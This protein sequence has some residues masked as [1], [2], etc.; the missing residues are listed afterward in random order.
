VPLHV[1]LDRTGVNSRAMEPVYKADRE[2]R[3]G[4]VSSL[5]TLHTQLRLMLAAV[6]LESRRVDR[7]APGC[8]E[9]RSL[10]AVTSELYRAIVLG[11]NEIPVYEMIRQFLHTASEQVMPHHI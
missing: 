3:L 1:G 6:L 7:G 9:H 2:R 11:N 5:P 4:S 8:S 10:P